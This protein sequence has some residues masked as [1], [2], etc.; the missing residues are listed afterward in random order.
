MPYTMADFRRGYA[1]EIEGERRKLSM[2]AMPTCWAD[3]SL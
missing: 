3:S 2:R 1:K